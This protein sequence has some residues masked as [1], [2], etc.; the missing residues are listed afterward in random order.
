M[1]STYDADDC[2]GSG[3]VALLNI[4]AQVSQCLPASA[5][6]EYFLTFRFKGETSDTTTGYCGV[7]FYTNA[8]CYYTGMDNSFAASTTSTGGWAQAIAASGVAN[9]TAISMQ[10]YCIAAMGFGYYDQLYLG[11]SSSATF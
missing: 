3:S 7:I 4:S 10:V 6:F 1:Y 9:A 5:G 2:A 11:T 8:D